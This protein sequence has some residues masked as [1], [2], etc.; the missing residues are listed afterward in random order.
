LLTAH[1]AYENK[2]TKAYIRKCWEF[3]QGKETTYME[4][5]TEVRQD[6]R[7]DK[8]YESHLGPSSSTFEPRLSNGNRIVL[9]T[10]DSIRQKSLTAPE[11]Q[12]GKNWVLQELPYEKVSRGQRRMVKPNPRTIQGESCQSCIASMIFKDEFQHRPGIAV[13]AIKEILYAQSVVDDEHVSVISL[14]GT[15]INQR[16]N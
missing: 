7:P 4:L 5:A 8:N 1:D 9:S 10:A 6:Y 15:P 11:I 13:Q 16:P 12:R 14:S 3:L 2:D